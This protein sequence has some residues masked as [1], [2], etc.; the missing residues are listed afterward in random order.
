MT[1]ETKGINHQKIQKAIGFHPFPA[2]KKV[3]E[4]TADEKVIVAGRRFGKT[5]LMA[6]ELLTNLLQPGKMVWLVA[7]SYELT[8][9][10]LTQTMIW[11]KKLLGS[12]GFKYTRRPYPSIET[13]HGSTLKGK[14]ADNRVSLLGSEV[15]FLGIDEAARLDRDIYEQYLFPTTQDRHAQTMFITT[16]NGK[17]WL[18]ERWSQAGEGQ[19]RFESRERPSFSPAMWEAAKRKLPTRIFNQEYR[20]LFIEGAAS[21]FNE[22]DLE[23]I[24]SEKI[25]S[26]AERGHDYVIGVDLARFHDYTVVTIADRWT[27]EVK[28]VEK[29]GETDYPFQKKKIKALAEEYNNAE[30]YV[31]SSGVGRPVYEDLFQAGLFIKDFSLSHRRKNALIEK[32]TIMIEQH[33]ITLLNHED[34]QQEMRSFRADVT[35]FGRTTYSAPQGMHDDCV[36]SLALAVWGLQ[37]DGMEAGEIRKKEI[38]R[39]RKERYEASPSAKYAQ[40][41]FISNTI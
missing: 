34:L 20:A 31:D 14:S 30:V 28:R 8:T 1:K 22:E 7:P 23:A 21:V 36:I 27:N 26:A 15:D 2:Q 6:Y 40:S 41:R 24:T 25:D 11:L 9:N 10:A 4:S 37:S 5:T 29:W 19:F 18:Y 17:N 33:Q 13:F 38:L 3:L 35:D 39:A 32:L 12:G 16:P